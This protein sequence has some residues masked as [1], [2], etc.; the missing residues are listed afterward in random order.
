MP[1]S[2]PGPAAAIKL[3]QR[4]VGTTEDGI[5]AHHLDR[6][7]QH[8]PG[9]ALSHL[10]AHRLLLMADL[11]TWPAFGRGWTR[12]VAA[13]FWR[14]VM[15]R[16]LIAAAAAAASPAAHGDAGRPAILGCLPSN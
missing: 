5:P 2:I 8:A 4:S 16:T 11:P 7:G 9:A 6:G 12:R 13:T 1:A 10:S 15:M 14:P 3:L